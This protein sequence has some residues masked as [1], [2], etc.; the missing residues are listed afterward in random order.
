[1][2]VQRRRRAMRGWK[3]S[4][5]AARVGFAWPRSPNG[6]EGRCPEAAARVSLWPPNTKVVV[7]TV[8]SHTNTLVVLTWVRKRKIRNNI[9]PSSNVVHAMFHVRLEKRL[10]AFEGA[11]RWRKATP[12]SRKCLPDPITKRDAHLS[13]SLFQ[14]HIRIFG[15]R[16]CELFPTPSHKDK[17]PPS[18]KKR[19]GTLREY[20]CNFGR[21][22]QSLA[23]K[24]RFC[25][26]DTLG[27]TPVWFLL[28]HRCSDVDA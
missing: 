26:V 16:I 3:G 27:Y 12:R 22:I 10:W 9:N 15:H 2:P 8:D 7:L 21:F 17:V 5:S 4:S 6:G 18:E 11:G 13:T 20:F 24:S 14:I 1:M 19:C 23:C 25:A 28:I